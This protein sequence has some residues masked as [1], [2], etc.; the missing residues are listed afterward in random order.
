VLSALILGLWAGCA[1]PDREFDLLSFD[2]SADQHAIA[3]YYQNEAF[4]YRQQAEEFDARADMYERMFGRDSDWVSAARLLGQSYRLAAD[5]RER[6]AQEHL[7]AG[8][9]ARSSASPRRPQMS[10]ERTP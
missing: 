10:S 1:G 7:Q 2:S 3:R 6:E 5:D 9:N 4:R 8:R